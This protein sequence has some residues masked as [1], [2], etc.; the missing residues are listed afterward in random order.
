LTETH[1]NQLIKITAYHLESRYPDEKRSFR[2]KCDQDF[3]R[4]ELAEI[5]EVFQWLKSML[6]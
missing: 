6:P 1:K 2:R 5:N 4:T 3:T